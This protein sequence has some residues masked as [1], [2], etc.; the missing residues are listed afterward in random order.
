MS[1]VF[2]VWRGVYVSLHISRIKNE[3]TYTG[4]CFSAK[5][6]PMTIVISFCFRFIGCFLGRPLWIFRINFNP[7]WLSIN[8]ISV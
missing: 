8:D 5:I 7:F 2:C 3:V 6:Q 4:F 1:F